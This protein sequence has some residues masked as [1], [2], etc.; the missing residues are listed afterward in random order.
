MVATNFIS[1]I[2]RRR[3][4]FPCS[5]IDDLFRSVS[6]IY[7]HLC[8]HYYRFNQIASLLPRICLS[9]FKKNSCQSANNFVLLHP[10]TDAADGISRNFG[11]YQL[12]FDYNFLGHD[13]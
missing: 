3:S 2:S 13:D 1:C 11:I 8:R 10:R 12:L 7:A 9:F 5:T 6:A 4:H